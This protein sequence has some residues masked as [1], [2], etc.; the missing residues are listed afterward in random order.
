MLESRQALESIDH[1]DCRQ[2][3]PYHDPKTG[4]FT[5]AARGGGGRFT[6]NKA[7]ALRGGNRNTAN[8]DRTYGI[9]REKA[10]IANR[11]AN[12]AKYQDRSRSSFQAADR[13]TLIG[14]QT[15]YMRKAER[16]L[17][18]LEA[19]PSAKG[20]YN[21]VSGKRTRFRRE[22]DYDLKSILKERTY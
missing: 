4:R 20:R 21:L 7:P 22:R 6:L 17:A 15:A 10:E 1:G 2:M 16:R 14:N 8:K 19:N 12:I 3:N 9:R 5:T 18:K 11:K 13:K